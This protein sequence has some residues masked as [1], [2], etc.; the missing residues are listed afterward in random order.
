MC[1]GCA[2]LLVHF[3]S[4][5]LKG[6]SQARLFITNPDL[7]WLAQEWML[8]G[9]VHRPQEDKL[10]RPTW[11]ATAWELASMGW[12]NQTGRVQSLVSQEGTIIRGP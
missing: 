5:Q 12:A 4:F 1:A 10:E 3:A 6:E 8:R 2:S 9:L 11:P 7:Q